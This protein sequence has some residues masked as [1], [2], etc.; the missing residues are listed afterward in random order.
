MFYIVITSLQMLRRFKWRLW[1]RPHI[2]SVLLLQSCCFSRTFSYIKILFFWI[3]A[4]S[5]NARALALV[6]TGKVQTGSVIWSEPGGS[7]EPASCRA[8]TSAAHITY[9]CVLVRHWQLSL[10]TFE[11]ARGSLEPIVT[12]TGICHVSWLVATQA[13]VIIYFQNPFSQ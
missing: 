4:T 11:R 10:I 12:P 3:A 9:W 2:K 1:A 6:F 8:N 5:L 13:G 7:I